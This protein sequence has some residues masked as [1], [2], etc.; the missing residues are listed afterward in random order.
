VE[1]KIKLPTPT[2][3]R[4]ILDVAISG[5]SRPPARYAAIGYAMFEMELASSVTME[6]FAVRYSHQVTVG[7]VKKLYIVCIV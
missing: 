6:V 4:A 2:R 1:W 3:H 7:F 5:M